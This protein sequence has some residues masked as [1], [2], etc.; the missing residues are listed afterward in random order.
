MKRYHGQA[1]SPTL[2]P[3]VKTTPDARDRWRL[4]VAADRR[5]G[6][7]ALRVALAL[8]NFA[9]RDGL[10]TVGTARLCAELGRHRRNIERGLAQLVRADY[11]EREPG[12]GVLGNGGRTCATRL[13]VPA[14][15]IH[16]VPATA[17]KVPATGA[18][19]TGDGRPK[20]PA[21]PAGQTLLTHITRAADAPGLEAGSATAETAPGSATAAGGGEVLE[22]LGELTAST[23]SGPQS[24]RD[25]M[26]AAI[27]QKLGQRPKAAV[28]G[29]ENSPRASAC[30]GSGVDALQAK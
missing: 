17:A 28:S 3:S 18:Q 6:P 16:K 15:V 7:G 1:A 4:E 20:V 21:T 10:T 8:L 19:G 29:N 13:K 26:L 24:V 22:L 5:L 11:L 12:G 23:R 9:N 14:E 2:P 30:G 27:R 25:V